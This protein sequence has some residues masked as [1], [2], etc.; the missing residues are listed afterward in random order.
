MYSRILIKL[1]GE[2]LSGNGKSGILDDK[3]LLSTAKA[4]KNVAD[5]GTQVTIVIGAGN[6]CR[7]AMSEKIGISRVTGDYMGM[8]GTTINC[9]ALC[10]ALKNLGLKA[11]TLSAI[12]I[13]SFCEK[14]SP[15]LAL[16]YLKKRYVVLFAA[17]IAACT[18]STE[19]DILPV[20]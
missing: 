4:I 14:Y 6:I 8:L 3:A 10:E 5:L 1:S 18:P 7:G 15:K 9:F 20:S 13:E 11:V 19:P 2:A 16:K 12:E 17:G